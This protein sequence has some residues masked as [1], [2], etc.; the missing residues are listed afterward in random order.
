MY[1]IRSY[2]EKLGFFETVDVQPQ[3]VAGHEDLADL[4]VKVKEQSVG[5]LN[6]GIGYGTE[7]GLSFQAGITQ[8]NFFGSGNK[9]SI[10]FET[11]QYTKDISYSFV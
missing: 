8:D 6:G 5:S 4:D 2:Y 3:R 11:N 10:N 1:A 9:A 7:T